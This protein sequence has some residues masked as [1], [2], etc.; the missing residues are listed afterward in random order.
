VPFL[1][2]IPLDPEMVNCTDS[3]KPFVGLYPESKVTAAFTSI[4]EKWIQMLEEGPKK[5][6]FVAKLFKK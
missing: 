5:A 4:A 6:S 3:G 1:G 2:R